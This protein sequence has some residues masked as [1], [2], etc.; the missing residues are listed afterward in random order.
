MRPGI[1]IA[2]SVLV[3]APGCEP[4][5]ASCLSN[6]SLDLTN[7]AGH[8]YN[9]AVRGMVGPVNALWSCPGGGSAQITGTV[10]VTTGSTDFNLTF[11]FAQCADTTTSSDLVLTGR[12]TDHTVFN[13]SSGDVTSKVAHAD[14]LTIRGDEIGCNADPIDATC[15]VDI[16]TASGITSGA[17]CGLEF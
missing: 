1:W 14:A 13:S 15:V 8:A 6:I 16:T 12:Y 17:I 2:W 9:V 10:M 11:E 7:T 3:L 5:S 4:E